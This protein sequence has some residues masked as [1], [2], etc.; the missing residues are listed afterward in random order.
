MWVVLVSCAVVLVALTVVAVVGVPRGGVAEQATGVPCI[1][2]CLASLP[3]VGQV[4]YAYRHAYPSQT[5]Y[6]SGTT[7][8]D[9][10]KSFCR[11]NELELRD[12]CEHFDATGSLRTLGVDPSPFARLFAAGHALGF[13]AKRG[14]GLVTIR[15]RYEDGAFLLKAYKGR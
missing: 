8:L 11:A 6:V 3:S 7:T 10:I 4:R 5:Y 12:C 9:H 13:G 1:G 2:A 15:Y 14:I